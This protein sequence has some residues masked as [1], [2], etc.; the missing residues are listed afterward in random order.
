MRIDVDA[1][2]EQRLRAQDIP[3]IEAVDDALA[4]L[5]QA[6]LQ[7][8]DAFGDVD[9]I[10]HTIRFMFRCQGHRFVADRE[11]GMHTHHAGEHVRRIGLGVA[12]PGFIFQDGLPGFILAV[13]VRNFITEARADAQFLCGLADGKEA[14][15]DFTKAGMVVEDRRHAVLDT[16]NIRFHGAQVGQV[17]GQ[18][19]VDVPPQS[20][21]DVQEAL[22]RIAVDIQ[23]PGH[24][25]VNVFMSI[26][27][28]R[29]DDA[30]FGIDEVRIGESPAYFGGLADAADL[31]PVH[32][33][34]AIGNIL[35]LGITR[36]NVSISDD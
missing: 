31:H 20:V 29:H 2:A 8:F 15:L 34:G 5:F 28:S 32:G 3:V 7:I 9:M 17:I 25:T 33:Y 14:V 11:L 23:A 6:I 13:A 24:G 27:E 1:V 12:D 36:D 18:V 4:V 21:E 19:A 16:F 22:R 10:S 35:I 26:D 30:A